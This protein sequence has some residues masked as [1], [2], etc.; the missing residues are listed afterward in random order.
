MSIKLIG[1][2]KMSIP[3]RIAER[4]A[5]RE[6]AEPTESGIISF[7]ESR[8]HVTFMELVMNFSG[9]TGGEWSMSVPGFDNI[10]LWMGM[11]EEVIELMTGLLNSKK[12]YAHPSCV[13]NYVMDGGSLKLPIAKKAIRYRKRHWFPVSFCTFPKPTKD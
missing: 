4:L 10:V 3:Q 11:S 5:E 12:I 13:L 8:Q 2:I 9:F 1:G 7:I 6:L